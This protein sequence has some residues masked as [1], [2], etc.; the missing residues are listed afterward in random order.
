MIGENTNWTQW[1]TQIVGLFGGTV[2]NAI[3]NG[4]SATITAH[5]L[6]AGVSGINIPTGGLVA[7][8]G[9]SLFAQNVATLW[10]GATECPDGSGR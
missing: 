7:S 5:P 1:D 8:G 4:F 2:A 6:T 10:G 3:S 9:T